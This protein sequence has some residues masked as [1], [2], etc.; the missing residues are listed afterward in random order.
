[1][2][3]SERLENIPIAYCRY[4][5]KIFY[6]VNLSIY[7][8]YPIHWP[9]VRV[10]LSSLLLLAISAIVVMVWRHRPFI[11]VGWLWFL[12]ALFPVI[13]LMQVG[14]Q[15]MA[16][17]YSYIPSI[18]ILIIL[19]W[20]ACEFARRWNV[21]SAILWGVAVGVVMTCSALTRRQ[22]SYWKDSESLWRHAAA[23]TESNYVAYTIIG[24]R[25]LAVKNYDAA[26]TNFQKAVKIKGDMV[27]A[28]IGL[29]SALTK[30]GR[31]DEAMRILQGAI[32]LEPTNAQP[33]MQIALALLAK[34]RHDEALSN[35]VYALKLQPDYPEAKEELRKLTNSSPAPQPELIETNSPKVTQR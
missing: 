27:N 28:R 23:V 8:P 34:G 33:R 6:P 32:L 9:V 30:K 18:G 5:G 25:D 4:L 17:R 15:S 10:I 24:F 3:L 26:I 19:V 16:D 35:L 31:P 22:I 11:L 12:G 20:Y 7:Y 13:G 21:S 14:S 2:P 1:M 29:G